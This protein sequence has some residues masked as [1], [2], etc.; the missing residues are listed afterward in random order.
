MSQPCVDRLVPRVPLAT[1]LFPRHAVLRYA[2]CC[3]ALAGLGGCRAPMT[4][5]PESLLPNSVGRAGSVYD[6]PAAEAVA[7]DQRSTVRQ[8]PVVRQQAPAPNDELLGMDVSWLQ[9]LSP[10]KAWARVRQRTPWRHDEETARGLLRE[11][12]E[13]YQA[14]NYE[15]AAARFK[16]AARKWPD[17][18]IEEDALFMLGEC[19]FFLDRYPKAND[20]YGRLLKKYTNS[21]HLDRVVYRQFAMARYW[22]ELE[23]AKPGTFMTPNLTDRSR[24]WFDADGEAQATYLAV[25]QQDPTGP[26]AD[27]SLMATANAYFVRDRFQDADYYYTLLRKD[28]PQSE[29]LMQAYLLGLRSKL[30]SYQGPMHDSAPLVE[31]EEL[32]DQ[33]LTQFP[34]ELEEE[35]ERV[36][37]ARGEI[38][39]QLAQ[40][41]WSMAEYYGGNK[42]HGA[43]RHYIERILHE[44]PETSYGQLAEQRL[45][46][47][48]EYPAE[49]PERLKWLISRIPGENVE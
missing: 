23:R 27:D 19:H 4:S 26:L 41:D 30:R 47:I 28:Y 17:S 32:V 11:G 22:Q 13:F 2:L 12:E 48:R 1:A 18:T 15:T 36:R 38:H 9:E 45:G 29:H 16:S 37:Q 14:G 42:Y 8:Q 7:S 44:Y 43:E 49:P 46:E 6:A 33:M 21:R 20:T 10:A 34:Y 24:P 3:A 40:R 39:E 35:V 31:A 5:G 25:W